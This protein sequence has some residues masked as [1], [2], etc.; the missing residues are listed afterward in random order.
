[1]PKKNPKGVFHRLSRLRSRVRQIRTEISRVTAAVT[2]RNGT[3]AATDLK[4][5]LRQARELLVELEE[6]LTPLPAHVDVPFGALREEA[7]HG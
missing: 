2:E 4:L 6:H 1:M 3:P 5:Q 7:A